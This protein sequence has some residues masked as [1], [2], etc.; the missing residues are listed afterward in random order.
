MHGIGRNIP[1]VVPV[2]DLVIQS[3]PPDVRIRD[4]SS[5]KKE[6]RSVRFPKYFI[7]P[8]SMEVIETEKYSRLVAQ[9]SGR[10]GLWNGEDISKWCMYAVVF[11]NMMD[12]QNQSFHDITLIGTAKYNQWREV[13]CIPEEKRIF[14]GY[15]NSQKRYDNF[16]AFM[17]I[18]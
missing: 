1:V 13:C 9:R 4:I 12:W 7:K 16:S 11:C 15:A 2:V 17:N 14:S 3:T 18:T 10:R 6:R 5:C 8:F